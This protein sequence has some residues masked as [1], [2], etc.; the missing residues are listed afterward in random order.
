MGRGGYEYSACFF[1]SQKRKK[2]KHL[3]LY[4]PFTPLTH[5]LVD[6]YFFSLTCPSN[7][8]IFLCFP[9]FFWHADE[10]GL[11]SSDQRAAANRSFLASKAG[12][13]GKWASVGWTIFWFYCVW[14]FLPVSLFSER[15]RARRCVGLF[16][17]V[18]KGLSLFCVLFVFLSRD[19][20]DLWS[21]YLRTRYSSS[22]SCLDLPF[23]SHT[24]FSSPS[25]YLRDGHSRGKKHPNPSPSPLWHLTG[26]AFLSSERHRKALLLWGLKLL[27]ITPAEN[28][29][30]GRGRKS[31]SQ[32]QSVLSVL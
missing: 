17:V 24:L 14:N 12:S 4:K 22:T 29:W 21:S 26:M 2:A 6:L 3:F 19:V 9:T 10:D 18:P 8:T 31:S 23:F 15:R 16:F 11:Y 28:G 1:S 30:N 13:W 5:F 7:L 20:R 32:H 25:V 27:F